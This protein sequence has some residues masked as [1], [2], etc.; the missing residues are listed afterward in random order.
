M[1]LPDLAARMEI[2]RIHLRNI[3]TGPDV[4]IDVLA[5]KCQGFSGAEIANVCREASM[6]AMRC[7][8]LQVSQSHLEA[9]LDEL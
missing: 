7:K 9:A 6:I 1:P 2:F 8:E 3:P 5:S 4:E